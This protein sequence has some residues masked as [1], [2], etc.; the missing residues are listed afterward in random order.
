MLQVNNYRNFT[1]KESIK[2]YIQELRKELNKHAW[3]CIEKSGEFS[4]R[5]KIDKIRFF[6][7]TKSDGL[8]DGNSGESWTRKR[9]GS[10]KL[11]S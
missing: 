2:F 9:K 10:I 3:K 7:R 1:R 4:R 5:Q 6:D 8:S 11:E